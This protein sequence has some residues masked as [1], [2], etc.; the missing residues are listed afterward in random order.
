MIFTE[1]RL[2][3]AFIVDLEP[4]EDDRGCFARTFCS[5]TFL[6]H[7]LVSQFL[8]CN[9]S[10]NHRRGTLRGMHFQADPHAEVKL[11]RCT[12]GCLHDVIVDLRDS[13]PTRGQWEAVELSAQNRRALYIP[14]GFAHGFQTLA[15][16]TE[17]LYQMSVPFDADSARGFS[18][19]D[20]TLAIAWPLPITAISAKDL[21]L[22][23]LQ[24]LSR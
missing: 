18:H 16:D 6:Q 22:P 13:S 1:T 5:E 19:A 23:N 15:D 4:I 14:A 21:A 3:G 10:C 11:V 20:P 24:H 8:Q 12:M 17:V 7:G 2:S 9:V